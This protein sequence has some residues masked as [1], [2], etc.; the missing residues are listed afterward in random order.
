[1]NSYSIPYTSSSSF[2]SEA[3]PYSSILYYE[4]DTDSISETTYTFPYWDDTPP[5]PAPSPLFPSTGGIGNTS[6][7]MPT[8]GVDH[9]TPSDIPCYYYSGCDTGGAVLQD[10]T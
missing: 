8:G 5:S 10:I 4:E 7:V 2:N 9:E 3:T 1:M 6:C